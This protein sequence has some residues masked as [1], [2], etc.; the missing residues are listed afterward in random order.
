MVDD[1]ATLKTRFEP[2]EG[3]QL[4]LDRQLNA[5]RFTACGRFLLATGHDGTVRRFDATTEEMAELKPIL[6]H[7]G[8]VQRLALPHP[9][10][11]ATEEV[12][13]TVDSWGQLRCG[14]FVDET[15]APRWSHAAAHDGW[16]QDVVLSPSGKLLA[17][18]GIDR[19]VRV[20]SAVDGAKLHEFTHPEWEVLCVAF[21][22]D[23]AS[24]VAGDL[25]GV[26][27]Q[28]DLATGKVTRELKAN[29]L[30]KADRLQE[31]G[32]VRRMT[33]SPDGRQ[34]LCAGTKPKNGGN[35]Q[36]LPAVL[37]FNWESGQVT[38]SIELGKEGDV[39]VT[40]LMFHPE[41]FLMVTISG[42]PGT[43]K[44]VFRRMEDEAPF[45]ETTKMPNC[46]SVAL[47]PDRLRLAVVATNGGS[48]GNGRNLDKDGK[49]P[50]NFSPIHLWKF[51]SPPVA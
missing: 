51:P 46:H 9:R 40:D 36:G 42:N 41:G 8:W 33:F 1:L 10:D 6:G 30:H 45:F 31:V 25:S 44:L 21:A 22:P 20:W 34:L 32:G 29:D 16:I 14:S 28:W 15:A 2:K 3:K 48:N 47:H 5:I 24:V 7:N 13:F 17:T 23:E 50:G 11:G 39:Y 49:Y 38:K 18:C 37:V 35:V 43:G 27:R 19:K 26:I 12:M 4:K